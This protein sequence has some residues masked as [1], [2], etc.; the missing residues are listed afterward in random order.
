[1]GLIAKRATLKDTWQRVNQLSKYPRFKIVSYI[2][3][4]VLTAVILY[5]VFRGLELRLVLE[6][7]MKLK[8]GVILLLILGSTLRH[9]IQ[10]TAW[11]LSLRMNPAYIP[12]FQAELSSYLVGL[13]LAFIFPGGYASMAKLFWVRNTSHIASALAYM[14]EK[15][16]QTWAMWTFAAAAAMLHFPSISSQ[17]AVPLFLALVT[18]PLWS[19]Y[20]FHFW[21]QGKPYQAQYTKYA[22][23][24]ALLQITAALIALCQ[25]WLILN[26][27]DHISWLDNFKLMS[28]TNFSNTLPLT[29]AGLGLRETFAI[30]FLK[31][32]GFV[33]SQAISATFSLF[34]IQDVLPAVIG[35][36]VFWKKRS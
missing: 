4:L 11:R 16:F 26:S 31:D 23:R 21:K 9:L 28:L 7:M 18:A 5:F 3:K 13:P 24:L 6:N 34:L 12:D 27:I 33:A 35:L 19:K 32:A 1:M 36:S 14:A 20:L 25:Y 17:W 30:H 22:P 10:L 8:L 2:F 15:G 29:L